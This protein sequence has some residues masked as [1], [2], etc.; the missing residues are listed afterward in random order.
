MTRKQKVGI[1]QPWCDNC[2][3]CVLTGRLSEERSNAKV[4]IDGMGYRRNLVWHAHWLVKDNTKVPC[5][6]SRKNYFRVVF[7]SKIHYYNCFSWPRGVNGYMYMYM[8]GYIARLILCM[9]KPQAPYRQLR[10]VYS[11]GSWETLKGCSWPYDYDQGTDLKR[12]DTVIVKYAIR[13]CYYY[14]H[15]YFYV[16]VGPLL[17]TV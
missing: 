13:I 7:L 1:V 11:Q 10:A 8:Q 4:N 14:Y 2:S 17:E 15:Y 6:W 9:K 3:Y 12:I 5:C 16:S